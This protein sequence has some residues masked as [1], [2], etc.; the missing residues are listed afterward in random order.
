MVVNEIP[1]QI[2]TAVHGCWNSLCEHTCRAASI[3]LECADRFLVH[4]AKCTEKPEFSNGGKPATPSSW[5]SHW[6]CR[7][8]QWTNLADTR[9]ALVRYMLRDAIEIT[10]LVVEYNG[11]KIRTSM[12]N[13]REMPAGARCFWWGSVE[14]VVVALQTEWVWFDCVTLCKCVGCLI[15]LPIYRMPLIRALFWKA[16]LGG[17]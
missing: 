12:A 10:A 15:W 1:F 9:E 2:N 4:C 5:L 17:G 7:Y 14:E 3:Y 11:K 16:E 13:V 8:E 6:L